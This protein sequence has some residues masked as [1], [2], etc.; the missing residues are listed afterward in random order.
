MVVVAEKI[1]L[2]A[3]AGKIT[4]IGDGVYTLLAHHRQFQAEGIHGESAVHMQVTEQHLLLCL[5]SRRFPALVSGLY[6]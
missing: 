1:Q 2:A 5:R 4:G 3:I 6:S